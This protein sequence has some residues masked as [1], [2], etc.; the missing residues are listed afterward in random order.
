MVV[1]GVLFDFDGTVVK[2][3]KSRFESLN[4]VLEIY[5]VE[6]SKKEWNKEYMSL[7]SHEIL[8]KIK[9]KNNLNFDI[10]D[11][12][13]KSKKIRND[14]EKKGVDL[15]PGFR[16]LIEELENL[17]I[18][19]IICSGGQGEHVKELLKQHNLSKIP[20]FGR[21]AYE[22]R[23]PAPDAFLEGLKR[24][25][26]KPEETIVFEDSKTGIEAAIKCGCRVFGVNTN[27]AEKV[28]QLDIEENLED[29]R[30]FDFEILKY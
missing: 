21:E 30:E 3:E 28:E 18:K 29:F 4:Q 1:R 23:K 6:I 17:N 19:Y 15:M 11:I 8:E 27:P 7:G 26:T 12:Y 16:E 10:N 25:D 14:I 24:I 13:L 22:N 2:S 9:E 20:H 5:Q